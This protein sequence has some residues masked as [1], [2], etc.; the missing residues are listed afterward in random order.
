[1]TQVRAL[2]GRYSKLGDQAYYHLFLDSDTT[3]KE[4]LKFHSID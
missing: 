2:V 1:M 4:A 3:I